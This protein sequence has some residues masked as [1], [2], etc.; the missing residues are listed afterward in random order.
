MYVR[1]DT[2]DDAL[3]RVFQRLLRSPNRIK[4]SKG[5]GREIVG[6]LITIN[7]PRARFSRTENRATLFTCLGETLWYM[8]GSDRLDFIEY[9]ISN[10]RAFLGLAADA[11]ITNGAYGPR[12]FGS[13]GQIPK[14]IE[15]LKSKTTDTRQAVVQVFR[16]ED[17]KPSNKDVPCTCTLQFLP[18]RGALHL[19]ASM[20]SND[21]YLGLPHDIFAFT[22]IQELVARSVSL[23]VGQ[24]CHAVGS[25]H[26]Y[27]TDEA[28]AKQYLEEGLQE[29]LAMPPM[30]SQNPWPSMEWLLRFEKSIRLKEAQQIS[31]AGVDNYWAD[32]ARL[33]K[34]RALLGSGD[35][36]GV[37]RE[38]ALLSPVY[39]AFIRDK[40]RRASKT[41][42]KAQPRLPG[43]EDTEEVL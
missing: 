16:A 24:Y 35:L 14:I 3:R 25:L 1:E 22:L 28:R 40:V 30:P 39:E 4:A 2:L 21:A 27:D 34:I 9:Y 41:V 29:K 26:L 7:D 5:S 8:S 37:V 23:E 33:L 20:R 36:R 42:P 6:A 15:L 43:L 11:E 19:F 17:L 18:R 12:L 38:K 32:L 31:Y 10:Y 13:D